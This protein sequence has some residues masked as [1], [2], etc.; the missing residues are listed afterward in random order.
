MSTI[1]VWFWQGLATYGMVWPAALDIY[2]YR[3]SKTH[4]TT[5]K[6]QEIQLFAKYVDY[7]TTTSLVPDLPHD[8]MANYMYTMALKPTII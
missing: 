5:I 8:H 1:T 6:M 4:L 2:L 7:A 3:N